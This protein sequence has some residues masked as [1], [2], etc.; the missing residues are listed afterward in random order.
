MMIM[1]PMQNAEPRTAK[2]LPGIVNV[3]V[4]SSTNACVTGARQTEIVLGSN[5]VSGATENLKT[6]RLRKLRLYA[7]LKPQR[8]S[9]IKTGAEMK[10]S[11]RMA[12][13]NVGVAMSQN[14]CF[15]R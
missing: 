15:C 8:Q 11:P 9:A 2:L 13:T 12:G 1:T 5:R 14:D 7:P 3:T 10:C 4:K 6:L